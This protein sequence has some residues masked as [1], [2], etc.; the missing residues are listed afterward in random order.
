MGKATPSSKKKKTSLKMCILVPSTVTSSCEHVAAGVCFVWQTLYRKELLAKQDLYSK[1]H[2]SLVASC[3]W[4]HSVCMDTYCFHHRMLGH[5]YMEL[6]AS[7]YVIP[8]IP[9]HPSLMSSY[10]TMVRHLRSSSTPTT[11][12]LIIYNSNIYI[13]LQ[14]HRPLHFCCRLR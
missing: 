8:E 4:S 1:Y 10:G 11:T 3:S 5:K 14:L 9:S 6:F 12:I 2:R 13:H 7:Y